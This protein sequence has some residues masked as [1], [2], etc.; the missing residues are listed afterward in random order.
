MND[1]VSLLLATAVLG[2]GA[3]S[4]YMYKNSDEEDNNTNNKEDDNN[5]NN[6]FN[7]NSFTDNDTDVK[8]NDID[9][10]NNDNKHEQQYNESNTP[11]VRSRGGSTK[12]YRRAAGTKRY[13]Y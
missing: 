7:F 12:R 3:A 13:Y 8:N 4:L 5:I 2:I 10:K 9:V 11:K 6:W 1:T